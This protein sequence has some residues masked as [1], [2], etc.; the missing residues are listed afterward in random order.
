MESAHYNG[1]KFSRQTCRLD[2]QLD[3]GY[4]IYGETGTMSDLDGGPFAYAYI[5]P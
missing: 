4:T 2:V 3:S 5:G 1:D